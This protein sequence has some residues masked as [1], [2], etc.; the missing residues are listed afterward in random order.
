HVVEDAHKRRRAVDRKLR[1]VESLPE[2]AAGDLL[3]LENDSEP[4]EISLDDPT[5]PRLEPAD[6]EDDSEA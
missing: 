3:K 5:L 6:E 2:A 4:V 1:E